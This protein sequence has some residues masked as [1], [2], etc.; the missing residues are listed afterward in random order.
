MFWLECGDDGLSK[1]SSCK[2]ASGAVV[3]GVEGEDLL[4]CPMIRSLTS[5]KPVLLYCEHHQ[6]FSVSLTL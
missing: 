2:Q 4:S 6:S 1:G 5:G 3:V